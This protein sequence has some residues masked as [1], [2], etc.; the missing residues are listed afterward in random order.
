[1][2][3]LYPLA[4]S[5]IGG[6]SES[7]YRVR[8]KR[9]QTH[10]ISLRVIRC[11]SCFS[12]WSSKVWRDFF[13]FSFLNF[14]V[15]LRKTWGHIQQLSTSSP[16]IIKGS[17][18]HTIRITLDR[19]PITNLSRRIFRSSPTNAREHVNFNVPS[20]YNGTTKV[21]MGLSSPPFFRCL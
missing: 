7:Y 10:Y 19:N 9:I 13:F 3:K 8:A 11:A 2:N 12:R 1:M 20:R 17:G 15:P 21:S 16:F 14:W 18:L 6:G 4:Q 5:Y